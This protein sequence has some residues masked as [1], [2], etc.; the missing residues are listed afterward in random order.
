M[1]GRILMLAVLLA[2]IYLCVVPFLAYVIAKGF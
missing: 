1:I 2:A